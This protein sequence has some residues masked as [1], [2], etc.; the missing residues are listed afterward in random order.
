M[1]FSVRRTDSLLDA[2]P[3]RTGPEETLRR[4]LGRAQGPAEGGGEGERQ[5]RSGGREGRRRP[6][7]QRQSQQASL[8]QRT[9]PVHAQ[10][11]A[12]QRTHTPVSQRTFHACTQGETPY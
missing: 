2:P 11:A 12:G 8:P 1:I 7:G 6:A 3:G 10:A 5:G 4:P 9:A